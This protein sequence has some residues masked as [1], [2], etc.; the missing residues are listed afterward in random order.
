MLVI[1]PK[2]KSTGLMSVEEAI[3]KRRSIRRWEKYTLKLEELSQLLWA[4]QGITEESY[5]FR[6]APSAGATYPLEIYI[7]VGENG[8]EGLKAGV[9][10]YLPER[11]AI[12]LHLE[13]DIRDKLEEACLGQTWVGSAPVI[14]VIAAELERTTRVYGRRGVRYVYYEVGHAAQNLY[15]QA[16]ALGLGTVAIGAYR[17]DEVKE[18]LKIPKNIEPLYIL[19]VGKPS[20][21]RPWP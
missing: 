20:K 10:H 18:I 9:Y 12:E 7:V 15:L 17:D 3:A 19:P 14:F 6:A 5:G 2:P 1:L 21:V 16:T 8:V 4:V 13:G 11:H